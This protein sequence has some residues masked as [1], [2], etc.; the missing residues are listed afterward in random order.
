MEVALRS[1]RF[2]LSYFSPFFLSVLSSN[3]RDIFNSYRANARYALEAI[4][5]ILQTKYTHTLLQWS[6]TTDSATFEAV[7]C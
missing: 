6:Q 1:P 2:S 7:C 4:F 3:D 5:K